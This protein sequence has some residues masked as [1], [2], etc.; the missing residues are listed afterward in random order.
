MVLHITCKDTIIPSDIKSYE[1]S[2]KFNELWR[3]KEVI[4]TLNVIS[5]IC[6]SQLKK[7]NIF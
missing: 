5:F 3:D 7:Y 6:Y 4:I 1:R 2:L